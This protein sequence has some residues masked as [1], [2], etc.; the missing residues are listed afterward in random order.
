MNA[1]L[2]L[3]GIA[4]AVLLIAFRMRRRRR[5]D[6][7][8]ATPMVIADA[9]ATE[10]DQGWGL[11]NG[12]PSDADFIAGGGDFGGGGASGDWDLGDAADGGSD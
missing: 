12:A 11:A 2:P 6:D 9:G 4:A 7:G 8:F 1:L 3:L 10:G 5:S